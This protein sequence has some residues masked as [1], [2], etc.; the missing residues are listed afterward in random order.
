MTVTDHPAP[1]IDVDPDELVPTD[2]DEFGPDGWPRWQ[3][4]T[5]VV[6]LLVVAGLLG[7]VLADRT[8]GPPTSAVDEGFLQDMIDHHDQAVS[9][10]SIGDARATD[11]IVRHMA[12]DVLINQ[13]YEIGLMDGY[14]DER[15]VRRGD[16]DRD[17]A[18][19]WMG[20]PYPADGMPGMATEAQIDE[21]QEAEGVEVD[22][23]FLELMQAH[24][25][26]GI[27]MA[28]YAARHAEDPDIRELGERMA[29][30]QRIEVAEYQEQLEQ[31]PAS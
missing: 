21:L 5:V 26:G 31:L 29:R 7:F 14:L 28:E 27:D 6:A 13:R 22:R 18:M 15:D 20:P 19:D 12:R 23:L 1:P 3:I 30:M 11:P 10:A 4:V 24:H 17:D 8:A 16:P 9:M 25:R 2:E